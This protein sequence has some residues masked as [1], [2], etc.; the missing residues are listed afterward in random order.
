MSQFQ[1]INPERKF[2]FYLPEDQL[3]SSHNM[4]NWGINDI[5]IYTEP[6][7]HDCP[8]DDHR[9]FTV[10]S[11][12]VTDIREALSIG[13]ELISL[14]RGF[15]KISNSTIL[16]ERIKLVKV[17]D[18]DAYCQAYNENQ[19]EYFGFYQDLG[20]SLKSKLKPLEYQQY[21]LN[22]QY[23]L[24]NSSMYLAQKQKNIGL[25]LILKYFSMPLSWSI[26]YKIMETLETIEKYHDKSWSV[27]YTKAD[28]TKFTNPAN[29]FSLL[30]IDARHGLKFDSLKPNSN[31]KMSLDEAKHMFRECAISY[32]RY[33]FEELKCSAW[34]EKMNVTHF[35]RRKSN[36][37][38]NTSK[39]TEYKKL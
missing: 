9:F 33:K 25:Y 16:D 19:D 20:Q 36:I 31:N 29:N 3:F 38:M 2:D 12:G 27:T 6:S 32:L 26:L 13:N 15:Y 17:K 21:K 30:K 28:R 37:C 11:N 23:N 18:E 7:P 39:I 24:I 10:H 34:L 5:Y 4:G 1:Y 14:I 22:T 8:S 35:I